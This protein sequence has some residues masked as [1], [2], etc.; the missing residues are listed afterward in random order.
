MNAEIRIYPDKEMQAVDMAELMHASI[1]ESGVLQGCALEFTNGNVTIQPGRL[2]I[3]GRLA[4]ISAAGIVEPSELVTKDQTGYICAICNLSDQNEEYVKLQILP[5]QAYSDMVLAAQSYETG[6]HGDTFNAANGIALL[7]LGTITMTPSGLVGPLTLTEAGTKPKNTKTFI[8][9]VKG[10][11]QEKITALTTRATKLESIALMNSGEGSIYKHFNARAHSSSKF[12]LWNFTYPHATVAANSRSTI[13]IPYSDYGWVGTY[14]GNSVRWSNSYKKE[15][16]KYEQT[17]DANY[18]RTSIKTFDEYGYQFLTPIAIVSVIVG[19]ASSGGKNANDC[20]P[21][22]WR[23]TGAST[24]DPNGSIKVD[25]RNFNT[26]E[27]A[28]ISVQVRMLYVQ[29]E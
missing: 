22:A 26:K 19:N 11:L 15:K 6:T 8:E 21:V 13:T 25:V 7:E 28:V 5:E 16:K 23:F 4:V 9:S 27:A 10:F 20:A 3:K 18:Y 17:K 12:K 24:A 29:T 1:P 2:V 14:S